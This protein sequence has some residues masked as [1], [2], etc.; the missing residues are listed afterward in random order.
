MLKRWVPCRHVPRCSQLQTDSLD[1]HAFPLRGPISFQLEHDPNIV[2]WKP[3]RYSNGKLLN[4]SISNEEPNTS[5]SSSSPSSS[6]SSLSSIM[7]PPWILPNAG[8]SSDFE[9]LLA[10]I[11]SWSREQSK[12][13]MKERAEQQLLEE[14]KKLGGNHTSN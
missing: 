6:S 5:S 9:Y 2:T 3:G 4:Q 11:T 14:K 8:I 12:N 1:M 7:G 13:T 10:M